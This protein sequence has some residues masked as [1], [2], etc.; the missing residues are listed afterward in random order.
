MF[1]SSKTWTGWEFLGTFELP[2]LSS[3]EPVTRFDL[4]MEGDKWVA[5]CEEP[6][7]YWSGNLHQVAHRNKVHKLCRFEKLIVRVSPRHHARV[8]EIIAIEKALHERE[9][10][11]YAEKWPEYAAALD[12]LY[13]KT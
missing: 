4:L 2:N 6:S 8:N 10:R 9:E 12:I 3:E 5:Q 13:P 7:D 1:E 11:E